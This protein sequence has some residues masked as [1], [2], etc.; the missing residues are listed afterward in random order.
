M[1]S[2]SCTSCDVEPKIC[3]DHF[4]LIGS[5]SF[6]PRT[7]IG[8]RSEREAASI[9]DMKVWFPIFAST[10]CVCFWFVGSARAVTRSCE[11]FLI[12]GL[13]TSEPISR[14]TAPVALR[15]SAR[16]SNAA[17]A[18]LPTICGRHSPSCAGAELAICRTQGPS[19]SMQ[20]ALTF[21][22]LSSMPAMTAGMTSAAM[23]WPCGRIA[24]TIAMHALVAGAP[25]LLS[26]KRPTSF[27]S[28]GNTNGVAAAIFCNCE[29]A[30]ALAA[31]ASFPLVANAASISANM[32][33]LA[34]VSSASAPG[35]PLVLFATTTGLA[36]ASG[37][38]SFKAA[39]SAS[40]FACVSFSLMPSRA[41]K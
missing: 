24:S 3:A 13:A 8:I 30:F 22:L 23:P 1:I 41:F 28:L 4:L 18:N 10:P 40:R 39:L 35:L 20:P 2:T 6:R 33:S 16:T 15:I 36:F 21:H 31:A 32:A 11:S 5:R 38:F 12:S 27:S 37:A 26:A 29:T 34:V 17:S 19:T 25:S 14:R 7:T 9:S